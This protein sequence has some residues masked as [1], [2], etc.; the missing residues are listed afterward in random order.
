MP[1]GGSSTISVREDILKLETA[2]RQFE[3]YKDVFNE[4]EQHFRN[5]DDFVSLSKIFSGTLCNGYIPYGKISSKL[6]SEICST[7]NQIKLQPCN[8]HNRS[9]L[10]YGTQNIRT[11]TPDNSS[12]ARP[13][14]LKLTESF[15]KLDHV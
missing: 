9:S 8:S 3:Q 6:E 1:C 4:V 5:D 2:A 14:S 15:P 10:C 13:S 7:E 11:Q 12:I